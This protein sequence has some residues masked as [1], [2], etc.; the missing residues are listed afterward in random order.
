MPAVQAAV[1]Q[2]RERVLKVEI[3]TLGLRRLTNI[4]RNDDEWKDEPATLKA[5]AIGKALE[6]GGHGTNAS[7][8]KGLAD[9]D[10]HEMTQEE[11][12]LQ[13]GRE[14]CRERVWKYVY[15]SVGARSI[16]KNTKR[17]KNNIK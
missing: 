3:G 14:S 4:L 6:P 12:V 1:V 7:A 15:I 9:K 2:E 5:F 16:Q 10:P 11:L 13:I 8:N 17:T